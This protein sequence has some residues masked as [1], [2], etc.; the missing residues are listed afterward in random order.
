MRGVQYRVWLGK[1]TGK[2]EIEEGGR[3]ISQ[4]VKILAS[5]DS[6]QRGP[7]EEPLKNVP[8][9]PTQESSGL[10]INQ[11]HGPWT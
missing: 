1:T 4:R 9:P 2:S 3:A 5:G 11:N 10:I 7:A 8:T 6:S